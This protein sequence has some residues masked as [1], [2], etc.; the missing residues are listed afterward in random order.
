METAAVVLVAAV[1]LVFVGR[2]M[3]KDLGVG[4]PTGKPDCGCG[5]CG[6]KRRRSEP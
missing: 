2:K 1:G 4:V 6:A 5:S 3:L